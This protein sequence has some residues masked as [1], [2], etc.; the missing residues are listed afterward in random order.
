MLCSV[1]S[2]T[3]QVFPAD[4]GHVGRPAKKVSTVQVVE[5]EEDA[6]DDRA[7]ATADQS[8]KVKLT[9]SLT[10]ASGATRWRPGETYVDV[11]ISKI[12]LK[13]AST[14]TNPTIVVS[15]FGACYYNSTDL[16]SA[17][18]LL[19]HDVRVQTGTAVPW[20]SRSRR[21]SACSPPLNRS[22]F[23]SHRPHA[24]GSSRASQTWTSV[25]YVAWH[26]WSSSGRSGKEGVA[27][28]VLTNHCEYVAAGGAAIFLAFYHYKPKKR[29]K[30][31]RCWAMLE[32]DE[33]PGSTST[34]S[35][36]LVLE[37]YEKPVDPKRKRI[38]L[39]TIK[40]LYV[41]VRV[42]RHVHASR[43]AH[44]DDKDEEEKTHTGRT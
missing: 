44:T 22:T 15:V 35:S 43:G 17:D 29:K 23:R 21:Q 42:S 31:C 39:F 10:E 27:L 11:E 28:A 7:T 34:S 4:L 26:A 20:A 1:L 36:A 6:D 13:D 38:H 24:S 18:P 19:R 14:Y 30:S 32:M 33:L 41:H 25:R 2:D 8:F 37:L 9:A 40:E 16:S 12:G 3:P 5:M